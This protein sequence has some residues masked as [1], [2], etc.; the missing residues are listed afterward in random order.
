MLLLFLKR[1]G[2]IRQI[3][4]WRMPS[5][6]RLKPGFMMIGKDSARPRCVRKCGT[7]SVI[8]SKAGFPLTADFLGEVKLEW[9]SE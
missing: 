1:S 6:L 8:G 2:R 9:F 4:R 5:K 7:H 3:R